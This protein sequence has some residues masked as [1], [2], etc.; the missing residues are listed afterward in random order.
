MWKRAV[1]Y[2]SNDLVSSLANRQALRV[3]I[4]DE[5]S[6]VLSGHDRELLAK[7]RLEVRENDIGPGFTIILYGYYLDD[8]FS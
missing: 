4:K 7:Q 6:N 2:A 8:T 1:A 3:G 5:P